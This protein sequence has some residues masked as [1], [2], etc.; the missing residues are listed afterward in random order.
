MIMLSLTPE[1]QTLIRDRLARDGRVLAS[2]LAREFGVSEDTIRRDLREL[3]SSGL[4]RR[5][6]GGAL[7]PAPGLVSLSRRREESS[8]R[9]RTL[10]QALAERIGEMMPANATLFIDAGSTN[11]LVAEAL[12]DDLPL[13]VVTHAPAIACALDGK[14]LIDVVLLGGRVNRHA[15]AC[16]GARSQGE[17][18]TMRPDLLVLGICG[19][20]AEIGITAQDY[21]DA[22]FK[23]AIAARAG[24]VVAAVVNEKLASVAP[25][26][27][28]DTGQLDT[29]V[30]EHDAPEAALGPMEA[31]GLRLLRARPPLAE[32]GPAAKSARKAS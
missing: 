32:R 2:D 4:C 8:D 27:V 16:L 7:P 20:D 9:K 28:L 14:P 3:A 12:R 6:Y 30:I 24:A 29:L 23:R 11:I 31:A 13:T 5:V 19:V 26:P 18:E 17:A 22:A 15:G 1:R 25:F 10:A 21:D